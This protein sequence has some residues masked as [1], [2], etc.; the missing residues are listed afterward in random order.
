MPAKPIPPLRELGTDLIQI[1]WLRRFISLAL[2]FL[3]VGGYFA[4]AFAGYW[5]AAILAV[6]ALSFVTYPSTS[7][8]LVHRSLGLPTWVNEL[9][10]CIY[11]LLALR[12]GHAYRAGHLTTTRVPGRRRHRRCCCENG[13]TGR[14]D[15]VTL[16]MRIWCWAVR[17][18]GRD[19]PW[20]IGEALSCVVLLAAATT[21]TVWTPVFLI[22]ASLMVAEAG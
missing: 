9:L 8:D 15:G 6:V 11:E 20:M 4:C 1:T 18:G 16:Q 21:L 17:R 10:L 19:G 12:S 14:A 22:Y 7:H 5:W 3:C 2:P 13:W